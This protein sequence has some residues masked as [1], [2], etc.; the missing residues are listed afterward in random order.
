MVYLDVA[1]IYLCLRRQK[2]IRQ[3]LIRAKVSKPVQLHKRRAIIGMNKC[4]KPCVEEKKVTKG[5]T[6]SWQ[7]KKHLN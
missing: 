1:H 3:F 4:N 7:I 6:F 5:D 2:N